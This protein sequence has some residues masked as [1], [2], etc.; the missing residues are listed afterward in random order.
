MEVKFPKGFGRVRMRHVP[1]ASGNSLVP[2]V[3]DMVKP[4]IYKRTWKNL[5]F[6]LIVELPEAV[7]WY[8][9]N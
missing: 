9:D 4:N 2:F 5:L 1:D 3:R 8:F 7:D 6:V